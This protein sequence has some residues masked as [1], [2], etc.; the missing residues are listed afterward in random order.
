MSET[1]K[2]GILGAGR[3][4]WNIHAQTLAEHPGFTVVALADA[5]A[6]RRAEAEQQLGCRT[7]TDPRMVLDDDEVQLIVVAT[8]SY[9]HVPL[10]IEALDAGRHVVVE[11]PMARNVEE[12][13]RMTAAAERAGRVLTIY[14]Q[15]RF[16]P[17]YLAVRDL[18]ESGR[19]GELILVRRSI[20]GYARRADWQMLRKFDGGA[21][22]NT[23]PHLIDQVLQLGMPE[24]GKY[25][26]L[27]DLRHTIGAGDA[28]DHVKMVVKPASGPLLEVEASSCVALP[29]P[30]WLV[31]GTA[32]SVSG[33]SRGLTVRWC[34]PDS[35]P[36]L[37][38]DEGPAVDRRYGTG[39]VIEWQEEE[40]DLATARETSRS[41]SAQFYDR[42]AS[43]LTDGGPP[44]VTPAS[45]RTQI[46]LLNRSRD[47]TGFA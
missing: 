14:Q 33:T 30:E 29:Q 19:L 22:S 40:V 36:P 2:V 39:E 12:V 10:A 17:D 47:L 43:T 8:P 5:V 28:E 4:G 24:G 18:V 41:A 34:D 20:H 16:D 11:K 31:A 35:L 9:T 1:I 46:E 7:A 27:A 13:D 26:L 15:R 3:S 25:E 42:L 44:P 6:E 32:G 37:T 38:V 45:V 23:A 21:L